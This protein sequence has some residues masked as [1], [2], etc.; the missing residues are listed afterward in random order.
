MSRNICPLLLAGSTILITGL[1]GC[2]SVVDK[3][4]QSEVVLTE[5][6]T[7]ATVDMRSGQ[8]LQIRLA[9]NPTTGYNWQRVDQGQ[10]ILETVGEA[11]RYEPDA[12]AAGML[13]AGG[14]VNWNFRPVKAGE[15][16]LRFEY[17][18]PW[19]HGIPPVETASYKIRVK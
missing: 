10:N 11:A 9:G 1:P 15:S 12:H 8:T 2:A 18:R 3:P 19:E 4:K 17:C 13:G 7:G 16:L 6:D 14:T 5:K